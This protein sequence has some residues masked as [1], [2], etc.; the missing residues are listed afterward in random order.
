[1]SK[2]CRKSN[3]SII[4]FLTSIFSLFSHHR[5]Y[6]VPHTVLLKSV[7]AL[8]WARS[9]NLLFILSSVQLAPSVCW[10]QRCIFTSLSHLIRQLSPHLSLYSTIFFF[11]NVIYFL[12]LPPSFSL[13]C[14]NLPCSV[15]SL[16]QDSVR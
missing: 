16:M 10:F 5:S 12:W 6:F 3:I 14:N 13:W 9:F 8:Q 15:E 11:Y 1:M 7:A 4:I 2:F